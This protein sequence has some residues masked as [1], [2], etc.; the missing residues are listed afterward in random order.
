M[1]GFKSQKRK[2]EDQHRKLLDEAY[3]LSHTNRAKSDQKTAEA[4]EVRKKIEALE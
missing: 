2:L 4:E 1:F 3:R